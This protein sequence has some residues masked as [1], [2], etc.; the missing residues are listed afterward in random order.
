MI[1]QSTP[2]GRL[3]AAA[4][5]LAAAGPWEKVT[6]ADIAESAGMTLVELRREASS[7][8]EILAHFSRTIDDEVLAK[9]TR[10]G[11]E[12]ARERVFEIVMSRFDALAPHRAALKSIAA[13]GAADVAL[14]PSFLSSQAWMLNAAGVTTDGVA[15]SLRVAGLASVYASVFRTWLEDDDPGLARTMAA[16]DRRLRSGERTL[17]RLEEAG[18]LLRRVAS[19]VVPGQRRP[20]PAPAPAPDAS[21]APTPPQS[22][23]P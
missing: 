4:L 1:D 14:L 20:S 7:K 19:A 12:Q 15:G 18:A 23:S 6:L 5:R 3:V 8:A 2:K 17:G 11:D 21:T 10:R 9:A 16:L 13:S 22:G